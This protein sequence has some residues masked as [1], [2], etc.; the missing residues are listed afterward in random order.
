VTVVVAVLA[1]VWSI[2]TIVAAVRGD[3]GAVGWGVVTVGCLVIA[4]LLR[5]SISR[6][7]ARS[8]S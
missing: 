7:L 8:R 3:W 6:R 1:V 2:G 5:R 4:L